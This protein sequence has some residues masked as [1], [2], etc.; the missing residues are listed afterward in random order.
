M[1]IKLYNGI[2]FKSNK[3]GTVIRQLHSLKEESVKRFHD[4]FNDVNSANFLFLLS[5]YKKYTEKGINFNNHQDFE[6]VV[7][8]EIR[9]QYYRI[10]RFFKFSVVIFERKNKLY[11]FYVDETYTNYKDLFN[12]D[13]AEDY[14]YQDQ[15]DKPDDIPNR[16][17]NF[18][19]TVWKDIFDDISIMWIPSEAGVR[20]D[21]FNEEDIEI[22]KEIFENIK[23]EL[24]KEQENENCN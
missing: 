21:I 14:H 4:T 5:I 9:S 2:K 15:C 16:E 12:K 1:S 18:R 20:Y 19:K 3:L 6:N 7:I 23:K 24:K 10:G 17:W 11:G 8:N 22:T 13:I